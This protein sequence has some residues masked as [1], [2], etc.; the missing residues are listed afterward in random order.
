[1]I[2]GFF[3]WIWNGIKSLGG[4]ILPVFAQ[5]RDVRGL[6]RKFRWV[7]H[8]ALVGAILALLGFLNYAFD[9]EKLLTPPLP[10]LR[11]IW[12]PLLFLLVYL[13]SWLG[14]WLWVLLAAED[15]GSDFPDIDSAWDKA[16]SALAKANINLAEVPLFLL[17][18]KPDGTDKALF[19]GSQLELSIG[20]VPSEPD[21]PVRIFA[22][23]DGVFVTCPGASLLGAQAAYYSALALEATS[24]AAARQDPANASMSQIE[25]SQ[26]GSSI[27]APKGGDPHESVSSLPDAGTSAPAPVAV[28][29]QPSSVPSSMG[30]QQVIVA[31]TARIP[32][33]KDTAEVAR[34]TLRLR[35]L[36]WLILKE[37]RP[38]CPING[39][40]L[41]VP[42]AATATDSD[43]NQTGLI[44]QRDLESVR[45]VL[46]INCP[47]LALITDMEKASGFRDFIDRFPK[48][49]RQRRLGQQFPYVANL[50]GL[51]RTKLIETGVDWIC[52]DLFPSLIYRLMRL[53]RQKTVEHSLAGAKGNVRLLNL[54]VQI[55]ERRRRL[56][57]LLS[58]ALD[59][60]DKEPVNFGGCYF[61][62]TGRNAQR[63]Q[64]FIAAVFH[65]LLEGQNYVAWTS[66]GLRE[67]QDY[68]RWS[69]AGY[70]GLGAFF[71]S[72]LIFGLF[73]L[74]KG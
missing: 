70:I 45:E 39:I 49:H 60:T 35:H 30:P 21:A 23:K 13:L 5:A 19:E 50:G 3:S 65:R 11:K 66:A 12:L 14:W 29:D 18:G 24:Q 68:L 48:G 46:Q 41:L 10:F 61:A 59:L 57:R 37:R 27:A 42:Y 73:F 28:E 2:Y 22:N 44:C 20:A 33:L 40:L 74:M 52:A 54:L 51:E 69:R 71:V 6:G 38:Y 55:R 47:V 58:V 26:S 25:I 8:F 63:E 32:L 34:Q 56:S 67:E 43:A 7:I 15:E 16:V 17:L 31:R 53:D 9:L 1:M 64:A 4:M 36:C 72:L 62:G